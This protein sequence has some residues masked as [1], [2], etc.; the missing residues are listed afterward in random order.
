LQASRNE[1]DAE[2]GFPKSRIDDDDNIARIP[3]FKHWD[4]HTWYETPNR[5]PPYHGLRPREYLRGRD[6]DERY[7]LG[8]EMLRK[9]GVLRP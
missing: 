7:D 6:W 5:E 2:R 1:T 8:L 4:I 9:H 3:R